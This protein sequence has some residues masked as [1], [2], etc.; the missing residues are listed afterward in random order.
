MK[1][2]PAVTNSLI[3]KIPGLD[4]FAPTLTDMVKNK[5]ASM[6]GSDDEE[7]KKEPELGGRYN[8]I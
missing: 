5:V 2:A 8:P 1:L 3:S 7:E 6:L 4:M